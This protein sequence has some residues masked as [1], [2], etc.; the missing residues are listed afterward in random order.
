MG[1]TRL[2]TSSRRNN[3]LDSAL[4]Q[5]TEFEG[6]NEVPNECR[7]VMVSRGIK[8]HVRVPDHAPIL[9]SNLLEGIVDFLEFLNTL[10]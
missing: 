5:I 3:C 7:L 4:E 9:N 2:L 1:A 10:I 6:F 8:Y